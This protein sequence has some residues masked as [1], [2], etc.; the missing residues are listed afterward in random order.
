[1][2]QEMLQNEKMR[3]EDSIKEKQILNLQLDSLKSDN[4][5]LQANNATLRKVNEKYRENEF[6]LQQRL[7]DFRQKLGQKVCANAFLG[8]Y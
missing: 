2:N 4:F 1:M 5:E 7:E 8:N 6:F 3:N